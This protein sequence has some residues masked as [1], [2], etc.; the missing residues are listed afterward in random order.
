VPVG[1]QKWV[2]GPNIDLYE[3][4]VNGGPLP[5]FSVFNLAVISYRIAH[6]AA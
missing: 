4:P 6:E 5:R 2:K 1:K 3:R